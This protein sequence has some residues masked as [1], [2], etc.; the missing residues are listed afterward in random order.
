M[1]AT[2]LPAECKA[3]IVHQIHKRKQRK[4]KKKKEEEEAL[5]SYFVYLHEVNCLVSYWVN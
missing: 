3:H 4:F 2:V 1:A 5:A